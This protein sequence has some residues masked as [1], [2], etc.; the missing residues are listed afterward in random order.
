MRVDDHSF[1]LSKLGGPHSVVTSYWDSSVDAHTNTTY[2]VD[3]CHHLKKS[4]DAKKTEECPNGTRGRSPVV[5]LAPASSNH[6]CSM[7]HYSI[8]QGHD[9]HHYEGSCDRGELGERWRLAIR[10]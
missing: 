3:I 5:T 7:R 8:S 6:W 4:G 2:T 10:I 9:R 1:D